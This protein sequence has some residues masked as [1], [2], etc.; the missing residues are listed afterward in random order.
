MPC[1]AQ[2]I[3]RRDDSSAA[4]CAASPKNRLARH[5]ATLGNA[6]PHPMYRKLGIFFDSYRSASWNWHSRVLPSLVCRR[7]LPSLSPLRTCTKDDSVKSDWRLMTMSNGPPSYRR[8]CVVLP[9]P[10]PTLV[11]LAK[12]LSMSFTLPHYSDGF[13]LSRVSKY[14]QR[15][16]AGEH[17]MPRSSHR[18]HI[19]H[20]TNESNCIKRE[21]I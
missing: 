3:S 15:L 13:G 17:T 20:R 6:Q 10:L 19:Q 11:S 4:R 7:R 12:S 9:Y 21:T 5:N 14:C 1:H 2:P 8:G 18:L 16:R